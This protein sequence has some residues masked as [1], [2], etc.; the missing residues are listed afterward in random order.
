MGDMEGNGDVDWCIWVTR[1]EMERCQS[2]N[3]VQYG[4]NW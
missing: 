4:R 3:C 1:Q 2:V